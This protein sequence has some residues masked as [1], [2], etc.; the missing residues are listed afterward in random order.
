MTRD[1]TPRGA[2][3]VFVRWLFFLN[4]AIWAALAVVS[5]ARMKDSG[6]IPLWAALVIAVLMFGN[7]AAML[8]SG[9]L[10]G[11]R[12]KLFYY[13][14][15][16]LLLVNILLTFTDQFGALD[17]ATLLIDLVLLALLLIGRKQFAAR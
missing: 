8:A 15:L 7:A 3:T 9:M 14:A 2:G 17:L 16:L 4:A 10:I 11:R 1:P 5:L 6:A 12:R 13:P